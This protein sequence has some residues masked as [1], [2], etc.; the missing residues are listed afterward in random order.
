MLEKIKMC[1]VQTFCTVYCWNRNDTPKLQMHKKK[2]SEYEHSE[3][4]TRTTFIISIQSNAS[5]CLGT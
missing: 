4:R 2:L 1:T 3:F 5:K